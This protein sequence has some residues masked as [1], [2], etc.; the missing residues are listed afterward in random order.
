[1]RTESKSKPAVYQSNHRNQN[2]SKTREAASSWQPEESK[3][4]RDELREIVIGLL[5]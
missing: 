3:L 5:G 2:T 1:M 4:S